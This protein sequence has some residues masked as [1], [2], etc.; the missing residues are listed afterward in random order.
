[1]LSKTGVAHFKVVILYK[2]CKFFIENIT[3]KNPATSSVNGG[4]TPLHEAAEN[5]HF[6]ICKLITANIE[7][8]NPQNAFGQTPSCLFINFM[9]KNVFTGPTMVYQ[10][11]ASKN[12]W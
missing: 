3:N 2:I 1:M 12:P 4:T 5:G 9:I 6:E 8:K 10:V 7:A 11:E